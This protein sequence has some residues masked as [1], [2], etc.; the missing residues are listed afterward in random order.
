VLSEWEA[1]DSQNSKISYIKVGRNLENNLI[2]LLI[3]IA[4]EIEA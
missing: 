2:L 4:G 1:I 3:F